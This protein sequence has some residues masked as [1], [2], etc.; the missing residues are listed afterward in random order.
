VSAIRRLD[1][2]LEASPSTPEASAAQAQTES[3]FAYKWHRR[4][5]YE[6]PGLAA[7]TRQWLLEKYCGGD[8]SLLARWLEPG[9]Q[10]ILDAGC[11]AGYSAML[12]F[13][14]HLV[15]H[16]Y[17]GVDISDAVDVAR[18]RFAQAGL[19]G[20]FLRADL[21]D[22]PIPDGSIDLIFSEGVLHHT[23]DTGA[24][25]RALARKL[26]PG[27]RFL[28][29]VYARKGPIREFTDD[30]VRRHLAPLSDEA[31]WEALRPL[32]R[33]GIALGELKADVD[34]PEPIPWLGIQ[35]GPIDVQRFFY[36]AVMKA[37]YR[38]DFTEDEMQHINFDWYRPTN[39]HRHTEAEVRR[40]C[41]EAG[42]AIERLNAE[43]SGYAVVAIRESGAA[44]AG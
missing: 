13:G 9:P 18:E 44:S 6:S 24:A 4:E 16:D 40:F 11:G 22:L 2:D 5:S 14:E 23:D 32:T 20:E 31:A 29:Y 28:F 21:N 8:A 17:L 27:G 1:L 36:Y 35:A 30:L 43:P 12:F 34:V 7:F 10:L 42:L 19:P 39:C 38:P 25:L 3:A 26:R 41:R 37:Y 33:L 15:H